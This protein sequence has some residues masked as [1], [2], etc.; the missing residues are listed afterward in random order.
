MFY[1]CDLH[2]YIII[3]LNFRSFSVNEVPLGK[4]NKKTME[5]KAIIPGQKSFNKTYIDLVLQ[6]KVFRKD[7]EYYLENQFIKDCEANRHRKVLKFLNHCKKIKDDICLMHS[8]T[9][10][11]L[12]FDGP[13]KIILS[14]LRGYILTDGKAKL[15]WSDTEIIQAFNVCKHLLSL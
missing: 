13:K 7:L 6:S 15:P 1:F 9:T 2:F 12:D 11:L 14:K 5:K 3:I 10:P 8:I 4:K